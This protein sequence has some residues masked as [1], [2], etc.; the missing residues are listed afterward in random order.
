[1]SSDQR[2]VFHIDAYSPETIPMAKL[3]EY[4]ADF[5]ALL[6][7]DHAV[8]FT[9][10]ESGSTKLAARV[11]FEDEPK[12]R[13]RLKTLRRGEPSHDLLKVFRKIDDQLAND[14]AEGRI[15]TEGQD[16]DTAELLTFPGRTR[17]KPLTYGPFNQDGHLDGI[18]IAVGG[19]D[20]TVSLR[21]QNGPTTYSNCDTTRTIARGLAQ[22]LFEPVRIHGI[23]RWT[24]E[25]H[26]DWTLVRFRVQRFEALK[27]GSLR[28]AVNALRAV[29]GSGWTEVANPL[30]ELADMRREDGDELH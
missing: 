5:A 14:N 7:R 3:A 22:H 27:T 18:L 9:G 21:L 13:S 11:E 29:K 8:H 23:G 19:K 28:E 6:G 16:G 17:P 1:M 4:M 25:A 24:R 15:Y 26:G 12:V 2:I 10:V 20:E 30:E